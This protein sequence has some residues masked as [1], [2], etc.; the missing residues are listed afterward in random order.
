MPWETYIKH[1]RTLPGRPSGPCVTVTKSARALY[2]N[3]QAAR[4][5]GLQAGQRAVVLFDRTERIAALK[6]ESRDSDGWLVRGD[7]GDALLVSCGGFLRE[8]EAVPGYYRCELLTVESE[9]LLSFR[10]SEGRLPPKG[11]VA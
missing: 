7:R 9:D 8:V 5:S 6:V 3:A 2:I 10:L 4:L 1:S 11:A